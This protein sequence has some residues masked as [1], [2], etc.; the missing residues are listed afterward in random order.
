MAYHIIGGGEEGDKTLVRTKEQ[1][2]HSL[3]YMIAVAVQDG[4]VMP[5]QDEPARIARPDVQ[6][7]LRKVSVH[8]LDDYT[9]RFPEEMP[10]R[11]TVVLADGQ[12]LSK[13]KE[14]YEGFHTRP[15]AWETVVEKFERLSSGRADSTL[16]RQIVQLVDQLESIQVGDLVRL[17]EQVRQS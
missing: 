11:V 2:D 14:D 13:E 8:A 6:T 7:L 16:R 17:L 12:T 4:R 9:R 10:C 1:A 15:M 3:P 5:E